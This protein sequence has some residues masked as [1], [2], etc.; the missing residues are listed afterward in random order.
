MRCYYTTRVEI[1]RSTLA[2]NSAPSGI[3][4]TQ[5]SGPTNLIRTILAWSPSG[6]AVVCADESPVSLSCW[7]IYGN[8]GGD[9]VGCISGQAAQN[10][11]F[12]ADPL[13]CD[14]AGDDLTLE[15]SSPCAPENSGSCGLVGAY[16]SGCSVVAADD[17][18][19]LQSWGGIKAL[20]RQ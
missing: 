8:S 20:Y 16:P 14:L 12:S 2:G 11:N 4:S 9:W 18:L 3:L 15:A 5:F 17:Y 6:A 19:R 1:L 7:D 10:G 13:F